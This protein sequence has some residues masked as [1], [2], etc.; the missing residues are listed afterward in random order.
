MPKTIDILVQDSIGNGIFGAKGYVG[1]KSGARLYEA[2]KGAI[3]SPKG[4]MT[5]SVGNLLTPQYIWV[6][7]PNKNFESKQ[8][9]R[10]S[11]KTPYKFEIPKASQEIEETIVIGKKP[12]KKTKKSKTNQYIILAGAILLGGLIIFISIKKNKK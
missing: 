6:K 9:Y 3:S 12:I 4:E 2:N 11:K 7:E 8:L 1:T 10:R 5:L